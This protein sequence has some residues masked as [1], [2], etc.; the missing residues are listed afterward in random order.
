MNAE[1]LPAALLFFLL[2]PLCAYAQQGASAAHPLIGTWKLVSV[3]RDA[4]PSGEKAGLMGPNP[5]GYITYGSDGRMMVLIV[6]SGRKAPRDAA[7]T[8]AEAAALFKSMTAYAGK[9]SVQGDRVVHEVD[10]S[11]NEPWT[12]TK[13][14][15]F[16]KLEGKHLHLTTPPS[17]DPVDGAYS[18]RTIV[19]ERIE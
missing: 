16:F 3:T 15:R 9:Y 8:E 12:K 2:A 6:R 17:R 14:T 1:M 11:W 19:W 18:T 7:A 5:I 13:Q 10:I 4:I